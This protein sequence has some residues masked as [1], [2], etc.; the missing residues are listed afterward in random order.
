MTV[1]EIID[2]IR[3]SDI[4]KDSSW[5]VIGSAIG[6][7]LSMI[8]GIVIARL[9]GAEVYGEYGMIKSTLAYMATFSTFGLG[10]TST[11]YIA[12]C[13]KDDFS[14]IRRIISAST[15]ITLVTSG[16]M[17]IVMLFV[18]PRISFV[19]ADMVP[20]LRYT[21][22]IIVF[23]AVNTTQLGLLSG[24]RDFRRIAVNNTIVGVA[25]F[26]LGT[27]LTY[28]MGLDGTITALFSTTVLQCLL[29]HLA[30]RRH[31]RAASAAD[32]S[33]AR[34]GLWN[35]TKGMLSFSL[36]I[37][38]QECV[39]A[40]ANWL[41]IL[42]L[43]KLAGYD[44]N[45]LYTASNQWYIMIL[46]IPGMLRNVIL[47]HLSSSADD[48]RQHSQIFNTMLKISVIATAVPALAVAAA[49][50]L[51]CYFYGQS[52]DGFSTVLLI[53]VVTSIFG[54]IANIYT[55]EFIS[56]G[57][58][59]TVF[60]GYV[61]RDYGALVAAYPLLPRYGESHGAAIMYA[62]TLVMHIIYCTLLK[63][64]YERYDKLANGR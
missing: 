53:A 24:F 26:L 7:A 37:A 64:E 52:F 62:S 43:I 27:V 17:A 15:R 11:K 5:A 14:S 6:K 51:I 61:L 46:F 35:Q 59:W 63:L 10:Y 31:F 50:P 4:A 45:G 9:L 58:N 47:S 23:N 34:V 39:F 13:R 55:Q 33:E 41:R 19:E 40:S 21:A 44:E 56:R 8:A 57:K 60:W 22:F 29:N 16:F 38:L 25:M 28:F 12:Q 49:T 30:V 32:K 18:L 42:V 1:S 48:K 54:C 2:K 36:P 20:V 3:R